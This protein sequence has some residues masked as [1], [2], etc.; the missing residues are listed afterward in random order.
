[1]DPLVHNAVVIL[2]NSVKKLNDDII[3]QSK[4]QTGLT[5]AMYVLSGVGILLGI[6]QILIAKKII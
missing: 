5:I 6:V 3:K 1:M 4:I 2:N